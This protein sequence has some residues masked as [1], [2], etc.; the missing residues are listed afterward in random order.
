MPI[1]Q[2]AFIL[3][4]QLTKLAIEICKQNV[5]ITLLLIIRKLE[6]TYIYKKNV[7]NK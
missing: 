5:I 2:L 6:Y 1:K 4:Q 7:Q 3:D